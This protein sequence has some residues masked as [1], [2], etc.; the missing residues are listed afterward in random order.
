MGMYNE[1]FPILN[2]KI[3]LIRYLKKIPAGFE[4]TNL[5]SLVIGY[6]G[7]VLLW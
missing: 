3:Y 1:V 2:F 7:T 4:L 5:K 6:R